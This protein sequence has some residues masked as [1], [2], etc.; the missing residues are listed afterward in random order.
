MS[1]PSFCMVAEIAHYSSYDR[2]GKPI[3]IAE[4]AAKFLSGVEGAEKAAVKT[5]TKDIGTQLVD[6]TINAPDW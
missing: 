5:L 6:M 2:Y 1:Y 4:Y 3:H